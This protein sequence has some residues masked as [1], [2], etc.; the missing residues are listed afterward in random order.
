M[1]L[2]NHWI[3]QLGQTQAVSY[4]SVA[5]GKLEKERVKDRER[6]GEGKEAV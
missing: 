1:R 5:L 4:G 3:F 6:K 2:T